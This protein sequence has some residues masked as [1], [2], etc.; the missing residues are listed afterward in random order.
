MNKL[1]AFKYYQYIHFLIGIL[2]FAAACGFAV[3][4]KPW[5]DDLGVLV[6]IIA[7]LIFVVPVA[8]LDTMKK[9]YD[10]KEKERKRV[11]S[12]RA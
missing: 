1:F 6:L 3:I 7:T 5:I 9:S 11:E 8:T 4:T 2:G 10:A 12:L